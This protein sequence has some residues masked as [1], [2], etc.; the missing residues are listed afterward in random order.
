M[1][2]FEYPVLNVWE[3]I[4]RKEGAV[5][6]TNSIRQGGAL[7]MY[8]KNNKKQLPNAETLEAVMV[9]YLYALLQYFT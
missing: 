1:D 4:M 3:E 8:S 6:L 9:K 5:A 2:M 7:F